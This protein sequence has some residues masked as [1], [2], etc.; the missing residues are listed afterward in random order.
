MKTQKF[1]HYGK[2]VKVTA[3]GNLKYKNIKTGEVYDLE[4]LEIIPENHLSSWGFHFGLFAV[5]F[6]ARDYFEH[7]TFGAG[8]GLDLINGNDNALDVEF[9]FIL[10]GVG[11]RFIYLKSWKKGNDA[12]NK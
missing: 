8:I 6:Y 1:L 11:V 9:K 2:V 3:C 10:G 7:N 12:R 5:Y 4:E